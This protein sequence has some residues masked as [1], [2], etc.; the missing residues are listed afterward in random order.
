MLK[1]VLSCCV[2]YFALVC[3]CVCVCVFVCSHTCTQEGY[4]FV[5]RQKFQVI[6]NKIK[7]INAIFLLFYFNNIMDLIYL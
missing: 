2:L 1:G 3:V 4:T 6:H 7:D 5:C